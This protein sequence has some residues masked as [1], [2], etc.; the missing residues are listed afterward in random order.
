MRTRMSLG[1]SLF[2][3]AV[4]GLLAAGTASAAA[5]PETTS[6]PSNWYRAD[7]VNGS[8]PSGTPNPQPDPNTYFQTWADVSGNN[9]NATQ[10]NVNRRPTFRPADPAVPGSFPVVRFNLNGDVPAADGSAYSADEFFY[11]LGRLANTDASKLTVFAVGNENRAGGTARNTVVSTRN[12]SGGFLLGYN[13]SSTSTAYAHIGRSMVPSGGVQTDAL[14]ADGFNLAVLSRDGL[15]TTLSHYTDLGSGGTTATWNGFTPSTLTLANG[16]T[17]I[18][19]IATEGGVNYFFG[20][21]AELIIYDENQL[22]LA[23]RDAVVRY[24]GEKYAITAA[25]NVPE[26]TSLAAVAVGGLWLLRRRRPATAGPN[27]IDRT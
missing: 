27:G 14:E 26:P 6:V 17:E 21:L 20:D 7:A 11:F 24:L 15:T 16:T 8:D 13:N 9:R 3:A 22:G 10:A 2:A 19:Q 25:A 18:T 1:V 4:G 23:E 12:G 5:V